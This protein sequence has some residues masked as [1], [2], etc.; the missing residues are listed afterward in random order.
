MEE[1]KKQNRDKEN[2][3]A[4]RKAN[5]VSFTLNLMRSTDS[6]IIR[7]LD[8]KVHQGQS[9]QGVIKEALREKIEKDTEK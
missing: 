4:W 6:D 2:D 3:K 1:K 9:R 8:S 5:K 7:Y